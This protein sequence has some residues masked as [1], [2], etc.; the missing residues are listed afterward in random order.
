MNPE[1]PSVSEQMQ[2]ELEPIPDPILDEPE[3]VYSVTDE[4]MAEASQLVS[5]LEV[6]EVGY[7]ANGSPTTE[8]GLRI[9][10]SIG[11]APQSEVTSTIF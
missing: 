7:D 4:M 8:D 3:P 2:N 10:E 11:H 5:D 6:E 1:E 9:S